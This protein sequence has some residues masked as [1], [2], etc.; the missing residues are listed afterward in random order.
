MVPKNRADWLLAGGFLLMIALMVVLETGSIRVMDSLA[1]LTTKMYH[2]PLTVSNAVLEANNRIVSMH[3]HMKDVALARN[4]QDLDKAVARVAKEETQVYQ[5]FETVTERFLG[6]KSKIEAARKAFTDWKVIR[7]EVI[8]LTRAGRYDEAAA[9]TK[10]KGAAHVE[11]LNARMEDLI[12]FARNKAAAFLTDSQA[13]HERTKTLL[14]GVMVLVILISGFVALFVVHRIHSGE[15]RLRDSEE[16]FRSITEN[17]SAAMVIV[18][19]RLG[20]IVHWNPAAERAF[21]YSKEE[22]VGH[23]LTEIMPERYRAG[24]LEGFRRAANGGGSRFM[25]MSLEFTGLRKNG[26]EFPI[27]FSLGTWQQGEATYFSAVMHD[28]TERKASE[29][30]F[31]NLVEG[32]VQGVIIHCQWRILFANESM[33]RICGYETIDELLDVGSMEKIIAPHERERLLSIRR[34]KERGERADGSLEAEFLRADGSSIWLELV[35]NVIDWNGQQ[36]IQSTAIDITER[37]RAEVQMREAKEEAENANAAKSQFLASMSHELRTP[38]NAVLGFAQML[39]FD[40]KNPLSRAQADHVARILEGGSH[41]LDLVSEILDLA[42]IEADQVELALD[43]IDIRLIV[44][45]CI[46]L[47]TPL[48]APKEISIQDQ[49]ENRPPLIVRTD[50]RRLKQVLINLLSNAVKFNQRNGRVT[51][52]ARETED[53]FL[54]LSVADTGPGIPEADQERAFQMFHRVGADPMLAREGAGIGLT[55]SKLLVERMGGHIGLESEE[56]VGSTFW[57]ELPMASNDSTVIWTDAM[58]TGIDAIDKD[59]QKIVKLM[60]RIMRSTSDDSDVISAVEE[61]VVFTRFHFRREEMIME[62][63]GYPDAEQ[64]RREHR[65]V[66]ARINDLVGDWR[67]L[68]DAEHLEQLRF[69]FKETHLDHILGEYALASFAA[70]KE[71]EIEKVLSPI[72]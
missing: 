11:L 59:H 34:S 44:R 12:A 57:L 27:E 21:G 38:L 72:R 22:I 62:V 24:H 1:E 55:V 53:G 70:G 63:C 8:E 65:E 54:R 19:D 41:L 29:S 16:Q 56:G 32:S 33:T 60:N 39:Q 13:Q 67:R 71:Q 35:S 31:R 69:L 20:N 36:A 2:H 7:S 64:H 15:K 6:D 47:V 42:R 18:V 25:G 49:V 66:S 5:R 3:R 10:G 45:D 52:G 4:A 17:S 68:R 14:Y 46:E 23:P 48:G 50:Q 28:I 9:I 37:K 26:Q 30:R 43:V 40:P 51:V 61:L 58:R